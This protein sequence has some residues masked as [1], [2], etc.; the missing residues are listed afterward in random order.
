MKQQQQKP[1]LTYHDYLSE[2]CIQRLLSAGNCICHVPHRLEGLA[3]SQHL[4]QMRFCL[5]LSHWKLTTQSFSQY[6]YEVQKIFSTLLS[7]INV[8]DISFSKPPQLPIQ[9][10]SH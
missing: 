1:E 10:T 5:L 3:Q 7:R 8:I 4:T 9:L 2:V 6:I